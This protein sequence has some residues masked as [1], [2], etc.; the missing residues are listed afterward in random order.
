VVVAHELA[1]QEVEVLCGMV[2]KTRA[3]LGWQ[4]SAGHEWVICE[5]QHALEVPGGVLQGLRRRAMCRSR[6]R[7]LC[8]SHLAAAH[9]SGHGRDVR[10]ATGAYSQSS[11][12]QY[13]VA[14]KVQSAESL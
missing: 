11:V 7:L 1:V 8:F 3:C 5:L 10:G 14:R 12:N 2:G 6:M 9:V 13:H 4:T